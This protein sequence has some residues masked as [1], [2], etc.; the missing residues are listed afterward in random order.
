MIDA[1]QMHCDKSG[2]APGED[3]T[4]HHLVP[5]SPD[6]VCQFCKRTAAQIEA[7]ALK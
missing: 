5:R 7:D 2:G 3:N 4:T 6:M 1:T